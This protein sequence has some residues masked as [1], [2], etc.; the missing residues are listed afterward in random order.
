MPSASSAGGR[1]PPSYHVRFTA[2]S[3]LRSGNPYR[4][5]RQGGVLSGGGSIPS[6]WTVLGAPSDRPQARGS[7]I[8]HAMSARLPP[9]KSHQPRHLKGTY[10]GWYGRS[11]A[12]PSQ[13]SQSSA[14]G[15][16]GV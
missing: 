13:R 6:A 15:I 4:T 2:G 16:G 9:P 8:W 1:F 5:I 14:S 3:P 10:A 11:G 7:R 12:G